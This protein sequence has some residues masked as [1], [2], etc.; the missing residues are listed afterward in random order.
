MPYIG[1]SNISQN[2]FV[3]L[4][5]KHAIRDKGSPSGSEISLV[6]DSPIKDVAPS[7]LNNVTN[8][9]SLSNNSDSAPRSNNG[10]GTDSSSVPKTRPREQSFNG[11]L[12]EHILKDDKNFSV[13]KGRLDLPEMSR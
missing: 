12:P 7:R 10:V 4:K 1:A 6:P 13:W 3:S 5:E 9:S 11:P 2:S 8:A